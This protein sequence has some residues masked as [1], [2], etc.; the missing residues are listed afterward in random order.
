[1]TGNDV[2]EKSFT[3]LEDKIE[4]YMTSREPSISI[5]EENITSN[6]GLEEWPV[7][8]A[9]GRVIKKRHRN[10]LKVILNCGN[11]IRIYLPNR[12][13]LSFDVDENGKIPNDDFFRLIKI[14]KISKGGH[15]YVKIIPAYQ[16]DHNT[17]TIGELL[18]GTW[19]VN[20]V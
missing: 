12:L 19:G 5:K 13:A 18:N 8:K 6:L 3:W 2:L 11:S 10:T 14:I 17:T 16:F 20:K 4:K 15:Y 9:W 7:D 1:M